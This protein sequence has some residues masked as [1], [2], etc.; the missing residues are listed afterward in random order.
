MLNLF[1][2][3]SK[4]ALLVVATIAA[5]FYGITGVLLLKV[6]LDIPLLLLASYSALEILLSLIRKKGSAPRPP[7]ANKR[8]MTVW[9]VGPK[10][11]VLSLAYCLGIL[12]LHLAWF[13]DHAFVIVARSVNL[14]VGAVLI[15]IGFTIYLLSALTIDR[16]FKQEKLCTKGTYSLMRHP[17]YGSLILFIVPGVVVIF[18]SLLGITIPV[19]MYC[20]FTILVKEEERFLEQKFGQEYL[21]YRDN[22]GILYPR[23]RGL[24]R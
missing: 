13:H 8:K 19:F 5:F 23:L 20:V 9:G 21:R 18:G 22:V 7:L 12:G 17:L 4:K 24:L 11:A 10:F 16:Y 6:F 14:I 3:H 15:A 2:V 1:H